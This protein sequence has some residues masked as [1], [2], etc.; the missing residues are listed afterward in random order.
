MVRGG[1]ADIQPVILTYS[2]TLSTSQN[3]FK[4]GGLDHTVV[5]PELQI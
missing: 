4:G 5:L 1:F 3:I 2:A